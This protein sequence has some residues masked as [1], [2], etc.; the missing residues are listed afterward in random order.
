MGFLG[1]RMRSA[2]LLLAGVALAAFITSATA[3]AVTAFLTQVLPRGA[4]AQ[5]ARVP[6]TWMS[7]IG[8]V[9]PGTAAA[10]TG[11]IRARAAS[12]LGGV[13]FRL[14]TAQWTAPLTVVG[15]GGASGRAA[16]GAE[17]A[18]APQI[19]ASATL[20]AGS[21]PA[22]GG[23]PGASS[24]TE[25]A[26]PVSVARQLGVGLGDALSVTDSDTGARSRITIGG[27]YRQDD[28]AAP[29]WNL[30]AIWTCGARVQG[31]FTAGGPIVAN[32]AAF[33]PGGALHARQASW[34]VVPDAARIPP[35]ALAATAARVTAT[36][37]YLQNDQALGGLVVSGSIP[38]NLSAVAAE[39]TA[40]RTRLVIAALLLFLPAAG[41]LVLT[42]RLLAAHREEEH[43]LLF[44]RG[45]ARTALAVAALAEAAL[46]GGLAAAAG[47][48]AGPRVAAW[49]AGGPPGA[50]S[51][52][53]AGGAAGAAVWL[54]A[55]GVAVLAAALLA[56]PALRASPPGPA[57]A[58][59]G[60]QAALAGAATA[61]GD[62]ALLALAGVAVWQ[63]RGFTPAP[64]AD[65]DP[66]V[67]AAPAL[68][69]AVI[70][71]VPIR[72]LPLL[73]RLLNRAAAAARRVTSAMAAWEISRL[74]VRRS[75]PVLLTVL[76]VATSTLALASYASWRQSALDQ[77]A[78]TA[79]ADVRVEAPWPVTSGQLGALARA[80]GVTGLMTSG[81]VTLGTGTLL[82]L[83]SRAAASTVLL[84]AD[85]A[86]VPEAALFRLLTA[87]NG[88]TPVPAIATA[89]F[90]RANSVT[91]GAT[92]PA[93]VGAGTVPVRIVAAVSAFPT[94]SALPSGSGGIVADLGAVNRVL[95][96]RKQPP[97][98]VT[99]VWLRLRSSRAAGGLPV[100]AGA[101]VT[102]R[103][104]TAGT[105]LGDSLS[106]VPQ[107]A[108][109]GVALA[110][111]LLAIVG[112]AAATAASLRERRSRRSILRALGVPLAAQTRQLCAEELLLSVPA[113]GAG[114]L[115][116]AGLAHLLISGVVLAPDGAAPVPPVTV[117][118]PLGWAV[119]GAAVICALP[120]LVALAAGARR[121]DT[122]A[123]L[124]GAEAT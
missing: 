72:L 112:F 93:A 2:G 10:D 27:L 69:L 46:V 108:A 35:G 67:I 25:V 70:G 24:G 77:A 98:P 66:V 111:V 88:S 50:G 41:T 86:P 26:V 9:D 87:G 28:P 20:V 51:A 13:P 75:G 47:A 118:I 100:P 74:Q 68:A 79:G 31:C 57:L 101:V 80:P 29:Y 107:R 109:I 114:L 104:G 76:A 115:G 12:D 121:P 7:V 40:S 55:L 45:A 81:S 14:Y 92:Y 99:S 54:A 103:A 105:L 5:L 18:A 89:A 60:R 37:N 39:L 56:W 52:G 1:R 22:S 48:L 43:A 117:I 58:R 3:S 122:A 8:L 124:R 110:V 73:A 38:P 64:G 65:A 30:D 11:V 23:S 91:V 119:A 16:G 59:R 49:L 94:L 34:V 42:A 17:V 97:L 82:A 53:S 44:G 85:L 33:G 96:S 90:L 102:S 4:A 61:G 83:D 63:L 113:A 19:A 32:P 62:I 15:G 95:E 116:G 106:A 21:W 84:R 120:P 123:S 6:G 78:F 36:A 71:L